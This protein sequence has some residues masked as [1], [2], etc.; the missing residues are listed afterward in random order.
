MGPLLTDGWTDG[1]MP[2]KWTG[3]SSG[4]RVFGEVVRRII[5]LGEN[6]I[7]L[8]VSLFKIGTKLYANN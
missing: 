3:R 6:I 4:G 2:Y 1:H 8:I 5:T 7:N